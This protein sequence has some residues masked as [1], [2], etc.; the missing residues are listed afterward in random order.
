[1][2][3][4]PSLSLSPPRR[5]LSAAAAAALAVAGFEIG[6]GSSERAASRP[7]GASLSGV[8]AVDGITVQAA[9]GRQRSIAGDLELRVEGDRYQ[10]EFRL[11]TTSPSEEESAEEAQPVQVIGKGNGFLVG[12]IFTGTT[13]ETLAGAG[14]APELRIVSTSQA[15][16]DAAGIL[17]VELQN[18]PGEGQTYSPSVTVLQGERVGDLGQV[19][20]GSEP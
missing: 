3:R 12:G 5:S 7:A 19:A 15:R 2:P 6:C 10:V 17:H 9:H 18:W 20:A 14:A 1:M 4:S 16:I 8:Y 11:D 13:E